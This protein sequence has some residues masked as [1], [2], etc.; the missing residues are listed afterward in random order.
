MSSNANNLYIFENKECGAPQL[1]F[2]N[3]AAVTLDLSWTLHQLE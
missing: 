3:G 1:K 2:L